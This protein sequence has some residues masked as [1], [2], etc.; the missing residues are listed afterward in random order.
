MP[1]ARVIATSAY[2]E[3]RPLPPPCRE[4]RTTSSASPIA[5]PSLSNLLRRQAPDDAIRNR[6][7]RSAADLTSR[8][9]RAARHCFSRLSVLPALDP[10]LR[11]RS[12]Q[13]RVHR[14]DFLVRELLAQTRLCSAPRLFRLRFVDPVGRDGEVRQHR[15]ALRAVTA[16]SPSPDAMKIS[17]P[18][19][20]TMISPGTICVIRRVCSG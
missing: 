4:S 17:R 10:Q 9:W 1:G 7:Q 11:Q 13:R 12:G 14:R 18:S 15:D 5:S 3:E 2:D 6:S 16:M 20:R 8:K 19:L